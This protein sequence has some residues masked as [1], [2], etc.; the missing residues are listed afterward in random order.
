MIVF[1]VCVMSGTNG[2]SDHDNCDL[3][4]EENIKS[5]TLP[6]Q[7]ESLEIDGGLY[8]VLEVR[9]SYSKHPQAGNQMYH[10]VYVR[11]Y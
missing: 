3:L 7:G 10:S 11:K 4:I 6:R 2:Y 1:D 5:E 8:T 9:H